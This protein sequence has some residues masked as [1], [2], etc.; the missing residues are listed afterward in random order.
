MT[1]SGIAFASTG[2]AGWQ[3]TVPFTW[4]TGD[5]LSWTVTYEAAAS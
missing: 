3:A 1:A 2:N 5:V 4:A